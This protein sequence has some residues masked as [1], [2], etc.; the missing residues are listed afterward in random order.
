MNYTD[1]HGTFWS[2]ELETKMHC[3]WINAVHFR[4]K[5]LRPNDLCVNQ[6]L[7][8]L[9]EEIDDTDNNYNH[10]QLEFLIPSLSAI[11]AC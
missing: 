8:P 4:H 9:I 7:G 1:S 5:A 6:A 11:S 2:Q 3:V 10:I